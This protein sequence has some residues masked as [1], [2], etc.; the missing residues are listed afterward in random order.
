LTSSGT[1]EIVVVHA[2]GAGAYGTFTV[3]KDITKYSKAKIFS[4]GELSLTFLSLRLIFI[5][6]GKETKLVARFSTVE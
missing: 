1:Y 5:T 3:T 4:K 2:K 6:V